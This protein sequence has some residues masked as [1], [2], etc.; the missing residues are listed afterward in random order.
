MGGYVA[1]TPGLKALA[2]WDVDPAELDGYFPELRQLVSG[3]QFSDCTHVHEPGCAVQ[4]A[5]ARGEVSSRRYDSY[6]HMREG[7]EEEFI[8]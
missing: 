4:E 5:V 1:D 8:Y 2:L 7:Q 3:C 6:V